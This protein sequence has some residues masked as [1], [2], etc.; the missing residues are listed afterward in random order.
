MSSIA[1]IIQ[2]KK[3][4]TSIN[5]PKSIALS[6]GLKKGQHVPLKIIDGNIVMVLK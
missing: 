4:Q 5:I 6:M 3:G 1:T 2:N